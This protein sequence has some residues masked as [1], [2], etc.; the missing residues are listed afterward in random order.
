MKKVTRTER[1]WPA[2]LVVASSCIFRRNTLLE[3]GRKRIVVSTVGN[4]RI[5]TDI[6]TR[7]IERIGLDRYYETMAFKAEKDGVY[8]EANIHKGVPFKSK[9]RVSKITKES[10]QQ[11]NDM[12]EQVVAELTKALEKGRK[13]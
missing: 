10:D 4:Y 12:H 1:G 11:A 8:W 6:A 13:I 5:T 7:R 2:H 3:C 9:W